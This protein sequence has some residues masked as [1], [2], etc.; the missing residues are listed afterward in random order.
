MVQ[1]GE[2]A[3]PRN[4]ESTTS[5]QRFCLAVAAGLGV[6]AAAAIPWAFVVDA[7]PWADTRDLVPVWV[8][9]LVVLGGLF[10][11]AN[12]REPTPHLV[13]GRALVWIGLAQALPALGLWQAY[14]AGWLRLGAVV[15]GLHDA[16]W[17]GVF[18]LVG[19]AGVLVGAAVQWRWRAG[20]AAGQGAASIGR[21]RA[22][23][24]VAAGV[25][26]VLV[27]LLG[28]FWVQT[29]PQSATL[30]ESEVRA[31]VQNALA[32]KR[33]YTYRVYDVTRGQSLAL[34]GAVNLDQ[35]VASV[36]TPDGAYLRLETADRAL[37]RENGTWS[38][39][40][41]PAGRLRDE[42]ATLLSYLPQPEVTMLGAGADEV[43][44]LQMDGRPQYVFVS[45]N[46]TTDPG[47]RIVV[48]Q[49]VGG[50]N[51]GRWVVR[52]RVQVGP[53]M[54]YAQD[55]GLLERRRG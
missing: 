34:I 15:V 25:G 31:R 43:K 28:Y 40:T 3:P 30:S 16:F 29:A 4:G 11:L 14:D 47:G 23:W 36:R 9:G 6:A 46:E 1:V 32:H 53:Y 44:R 17:F 54:G 24:A 22:G 50:H 5:A 21:G 52:R 7:L 8:L 37:V 10:V 41:N 51:S 12:R 20:A 38:V 48:E 19:T 26:G 2:H 49:A 45:T 55:D 27:V 18:D 35:G 42:T 39:S 33:T 13:S